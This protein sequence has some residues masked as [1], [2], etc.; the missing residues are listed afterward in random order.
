MI[1]EPLWLRR[2]IR[3]EAQPLMDLEADLSSLE[4]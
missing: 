4:T 2:V 1:D 3:C